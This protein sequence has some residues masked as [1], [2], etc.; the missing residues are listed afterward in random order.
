M[1][2]AEEVMPDPRET[3]VSGKLVLYPPPGAEVPP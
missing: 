3:L 1:G 2:A